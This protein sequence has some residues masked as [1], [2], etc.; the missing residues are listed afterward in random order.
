MTELA[1]RPGRMIVFLEGGYDLG[2]LRDSVAATLPALL[3]AAPAA[4]EAPTGGGPG[5]PVIAAAADLRR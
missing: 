5:A 3:G 2:A 1:P 4:T